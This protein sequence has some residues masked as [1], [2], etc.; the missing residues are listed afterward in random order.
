MQ[1]FI[2]LHLM[3]ILILTLL[4]EFDWE[5]YFL[6]MNGLPLIKEIYDEILWEYIGMLLIFKSIPFLKYE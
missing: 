2:S 3:T 1:N 6:P 5:I 4:G